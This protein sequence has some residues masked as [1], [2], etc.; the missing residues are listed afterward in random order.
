MS[1]KLCIKKAY[2]LEGYGSRS[3]V[4]F[5]VCLRG[6]I[7]LTMTKHYK[8]TSWASWSRADEETLHAGHG[9][10]SAAISG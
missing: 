4:R 10:S 3:C 1:W 8:Q 6:T 9:A 5:A 7:A 2:R